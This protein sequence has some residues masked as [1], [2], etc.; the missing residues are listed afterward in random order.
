VV[1]DVP[2]FGTETA[3][4]LYGL[5]DEESDASVRRSLSELAPLFDRRRY[6]R[7]VLLG[8]DLNTLAIAGAGTRNLAKDIGVLKRI[9][10]AFGL[11]DLLQLD[12]LARAPPRGRLADCTCSFGDGCTHT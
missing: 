2:G 5:L 10:Q 11:R 8:G 6:N 3:I 7:L 1:N 12:L 9:T 4:S